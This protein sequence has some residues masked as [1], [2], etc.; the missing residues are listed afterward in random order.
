MTHSTFSTI[1]ATLAAEGF[2]STGTRP[3]FFGSV[4]ADAEV[5]L[6]RG[7]STPAQVV[8]IVKHQLAAMPGEVDRW[9]ITTHKGGGYVYVNLRHPVAA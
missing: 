3:V 4:K 2:I 9:Y 7:T 1:S 8:R 5:F 6:K